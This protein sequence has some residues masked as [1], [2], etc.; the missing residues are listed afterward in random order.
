VVT[1]ENG[2]NIDFMNTEG[3]IT[4]QHYA[5]LVSEPEFDQN[6]GRIRKRWIH[7]SSATPS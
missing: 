6:F 2:A 4:A 5:F 1:T 7:V 3:E